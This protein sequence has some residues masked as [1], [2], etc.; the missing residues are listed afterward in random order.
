MTIFRYIENIEIS[1][2]SNNQTVM[3]HGRY[4]T[5]VR[6]IEKSTF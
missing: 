6:T 2:Q 4:H 1:I 3:D 5:A